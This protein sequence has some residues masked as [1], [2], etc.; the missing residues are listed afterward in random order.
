M[1]LH[2]LVAIIVAMLLLDASPSDALRG[3]RKQCRKMCGPKIAQDCREFRRAGKR[4]CKRSILRLCRNVSM[5]ACLL[6][7]ETPP[8]TTTTTVTPTSG[9]PSTTHTLPTSTTTFVPHT[10]PTTTT[11]INS[12]TTHTTTSKPPTTTSTT[13]PFHYAGDWTFFGEQITDDCP[14]S[15]PLF[16]DQEVLLTHSPGS[17]SIFVVVET[18]PGM[19]GVAD[20][21][22]FDGTSSFDVGECTVEA[23]FAAEVTNDPNLMNAALAL[24]WDCPTLSCTVAYSGDLE[25]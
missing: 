12:T 8:T 13:G 21:F 22:G 15:D 14:G 19:L 4:A 20:R 2:A 16:F 5:D 3:T 11:R 23:A 9:V 17:P 24:S 7:S 6:A 18:L 10:F 25:H 1:K